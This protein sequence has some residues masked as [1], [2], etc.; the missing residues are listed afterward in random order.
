MVA[1]ERTRKVRYVRLSG[2]VND[3]EDDDDNDD[4]DEQCTL[5]H[6]MTCQS[7]QKSYLHVMYI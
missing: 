7:S 6:E 5:I 1:E 4:D 3:E 2:E